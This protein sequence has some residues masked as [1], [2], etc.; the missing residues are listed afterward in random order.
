MNDSIWGWKFERL[1]VEYRSQKL[2]A[3]GTSY[4]CKIFCYHELNHLVKIDRLINSSLFVWELA[5]TSSGVLFYELW[6]FV[7]ATKIDFLSIYF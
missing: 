1:E 2:I 4:Y 3:N 5:P 7:W 6:I